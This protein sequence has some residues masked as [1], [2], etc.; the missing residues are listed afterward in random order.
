MQLNQIN[1]DVLQSFQQE[2]SFKQEFQNKDVIP[3]FLFERR[4]PTSRPLTA[5]NDKLLN[6]V[7]LKTGGQCNLLILTPPNQ[8]L[9]VLLTVPNHT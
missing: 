8:Q 1:E 4:L 7:S 3:I 2:S 5:V 9:G 6:S